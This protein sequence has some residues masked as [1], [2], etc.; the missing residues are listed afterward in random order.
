MVAETA[1]QAGSSYITSHIFLLSSL[2]ILPIS[3]L[4]YIL[5]TRDPRRNNLPP[6]IPAWPIINHTFLQQEDNTPPILRAWGERYGELFRTRAGTTDFIW[7]NSKKAVKECFDRRSGTYSSRQPMPMA[8]ERATGGKRITFAPYGK[9]WRGSRAV[10]HKVLTPKMAEDYSI[11]QLFEA[12]QLAV[13][14]LDNPKDFY[15]HNRRYSASVIMQV[16]YGWRIPEWDCPEIRAI[17]EVLGRFVQCRK[18]GQWLVDVF[19]S[20]A[21]NPVFNALSSWKRVGKRFYELDEATWMGF[22]NQMN[23]KVKQGTAPHCFGKVLQAEYEKAGLSESQAAWICGGLIEAGSETT[24]ATLNNCIYMMLS[25]PSCITTA[26]SELDRVVGPNRTPTFADEPNLPFI[27]GIIKETLRMR[28]I[29]K[30][31]N[32]HYLTSD[33]WYN[34]YFIPEN[35]IVMANW[36]AIHYNPEYYPDPDVFMPERWMGYEYSAAKAA[37]LADGELRDHLSYGGGRRICAGMHV[38]EKSLFINVARLLWGFD[39]RRKKDAEGREMEYDFSTKS[40]QPGS[41]SVTKPFPCEIR[42]RSGDR[43]KIL[44]EEWRVASEKGIDFDHIKWSV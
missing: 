39:V 14:L 30:F 32:N 36:W 15:M 41:S 17:F 31:G 10:F 8:F 43:E 26:Q 19:P 42:V 28:P 1:L 3:L 33:D 24:S 6:K 20:L 25:N 12:K 38:A 18:P 7:L 4:S 21:K 22:W 29:N 40:L 5:L 9:V 2:S 27:R 16:T 13:D 34:G 35:S 37:T 44:R 11:I 23:E